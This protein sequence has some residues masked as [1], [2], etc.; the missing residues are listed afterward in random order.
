[1][2]AE[3][4]QTL[5]ALQSLLPALTAL[6]SQ[7]QQQ[8]PTPLPPQPIPAQQP[9]AP[10]PP[11]AQFEG[12]YREKYGKPFNTETF[13]KFNQWSQDNANPLK[14]LEDNLSA[15][16]RIMGGPE[17][18]PDDVRARFA[19]N[20][21]SG[22][23]ATL[24]DVTDDISL[25]SFSRKRAIEEVAPPVP[26][27]TPPE[28]EGEPS[29]SSSDNTQTPTPAGQPEKKQRTPDLFDHP[30]PKSTSTSATNS[31][32]NDLTK[33]LLSKTGINA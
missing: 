10:Q 28:G 33:D 23:K 2:N 6:A 19:F 5:T 25:K 12:W 11:E 27:P 32:I 18:V 1:M 4:L 21:Y 7:Q 31:R 29:S 20:V 30:P 26:A 14:T 16:E 13:D 15:M 17:H 8:Q 22:L 24:G 9:A 3:Q